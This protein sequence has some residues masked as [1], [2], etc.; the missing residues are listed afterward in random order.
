MCL[1]VLSGLLGFPAM[2][3][4]QP[5][6]NIVLIMV[7]DL[8]FSDTAPYGGED[9]ETPNISALAKEGLKLREFYNNGTSAPTRASLLTGQYQ[10][11]AGLGYFNVSLG[12]PAYQGFLRKEALTIAEV[13]KKGGY[14]TLM[15]GKWHVG[16]DR[17]QWPNQRGF[18]HFFGFI[19]GASNYYESDDPSHERVA[20]IKDNKPYALGD[21]KYL[22]D[23]I[24]DQSITFLDQQDKE[25]KPFFLYVAY[26]APHWP[27]QAKPEDIEKYKDRYKLGWDSLRKVRYEN[28]IAEGIFPEGQPI[29]KH[30]GEAQ[31][32]NKLTYDEQQYWQLQQEVYAAMIDRVDQGLGK[33]ISKL[34][35]LG[36]EDNTLIVFI[37]DNG[38]QEGN[39]LNI[40]PPRNS[41]PVGTAGSYEVRN[42]NW[43][44]TGN[45]PLKN[46]KRTPY[47]GGVSAPFIAR[48]PK[49]IKADRIAQGTAHLI[50]LA[51][52]FYELAGVPY[53][54]RYNRLNTYP[55]A[56]KSLVP[57]LGGEQEQVNRG[58]PLFWERGGKAALRDG[59]WKLV[60][61]GAENDKYELYDIEK[62]RAEN[63]DLAEQYP[64]VVAKLKNEYAAWAQKNE[65]VDYKKLKDLPVKNNKAGE[66]NNNGGIQ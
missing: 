2:A 57:L 54:E 55:L 43:S 44:Q 50:D 1:L 24:T 13:L 45:S 8:G 9:I 15:S 14:S 61:A 38:A 33:I 11:K 28:A 49:L 10:Y 25:K 29:A 40:Y 47:E 6:P 65:V 16:D 53:P 66:R 30:D 37:S 63:N 48:F 23:E 32:W 18:D 3:Q 58:A 42:S 51:P 39:G 26:N 52:T 5:R 36:K 64:E 34:K 17:D 7:D 41:G 59:Q 19:G 31:A 56:G 46:D 27:L 4:K 21:G 60:I 35:A 62:D 20:L 22:T 12:L